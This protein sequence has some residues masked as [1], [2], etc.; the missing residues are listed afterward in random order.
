MAYSRDWIITRLQEADLFVGVDQA[1]ME[2]LGP[3]CRVRQVAAGD[4]VAWESDPAGVVFFIAEGHVAVERVTDDGLQVHLATLVPG[5]LAGEL[6]LFLEQPRNA[7][8]RALDACVLVTI[9]G[10]ELLREIEADGKFARAIIGGLARRIHRST[11]DKT[12]RSW[13][14]PRR[15][16][17]LLVERAKRD[18][19]KTAEGYVVDIGVSQGQL[20]NELGATRE[21]LNRTIRDLREEGLLKWEG[22]TVTLLRAKALQALSRGQ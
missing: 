4:L 7:D 2:R 22:Q 15:L 13:K 8:L 21:A 17:Y 5:E 14:L 18:G 10:R 9:D 1:I 12:R 16:A 20:A 19:N 6:S 11:E 3:N